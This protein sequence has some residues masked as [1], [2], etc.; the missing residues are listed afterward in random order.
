M[1]PEGELE[2]CILGPLKVV[3]K[4]RPLNL[5]RTKQRALLGKRLS[6]A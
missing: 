1:R 6:E 4:G 2:F 3:A 5:S